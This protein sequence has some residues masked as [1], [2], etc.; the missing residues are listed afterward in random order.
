MLR[1]SCL[2]R[3]ADELPVDV[4][5]SEVHQE[6]RDGDADQHHYGC[7]YRLERAAPEDGES[8]DDGCASA[9]ADEAGERPPRSPNAMAMTVACLCSLTSG[10][11]FLRTNA[12]I[13]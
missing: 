7:P 3:A 1:S 2:R 10:D 4:S 8:G 12:I 5:D 9:D 6:S 11:F 13:I